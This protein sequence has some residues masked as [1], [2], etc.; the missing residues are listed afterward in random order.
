[1]YKMKLEERWAVGHIYGGEC[2]KSYLSL[3]FAPSFP[4]F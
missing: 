1:M 3:T 4:K 2:G